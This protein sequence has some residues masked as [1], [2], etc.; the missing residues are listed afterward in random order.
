MSLAPLLDLLILS[1]SLFCLSLN[2]THCTDQ[3]PTRRM[4]KT[5]FICSS[6]AMIDHN[7]PNSKYYKFTNN[8]NNLIIISLLVSTVYFK[9]SANY[10]TVINYALNVKHRSVQRSF[11]HAKLSRKYKYIFP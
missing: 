11:Q 2:Q 9:H 6:L 7:R 8:N 10:I 4:H 3:T 1:L 5:V